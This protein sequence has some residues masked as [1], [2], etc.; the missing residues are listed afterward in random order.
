MS[1][2]IFPNQHKPISKHCLKR[3]LQTL[4]SVPDWESVKPVE[5][6]DGE[7]EESSAH[8]PKK[9]KRRTKKRKKV[10]GTGAEDEQNVEEREA[11][12]LKTPVKKR[13][14]KPKQKQQDKEGNEEAKKSE[15]GSSAA[16][17]PSV[18][19]LTRQQWKNKIKS[20]RRCKN[21]FLN[22]ADK[23]TEESVKQKSGPVLGLSELQKVQN[24]QPHERIAS[25]EVGDIVKPFNKHK[26]KKFKAVTNGSNQTKQTE[27]KTNPH[28]QCEKQKPVKTGPNPNLQLKANK[29]RRILNTHATS[30]KNNSTQEDEVQD[31]IQ[32]NT[33]EEEVE[34]EKGVTD[35]SSALRSRMEKR[36]ESARFRYINEL[37]YT[38]TSGE[39]KRMFKQDPDAIGIYHKGYTAQVKY[40]P[41]NP[42]DSI[43]AFIQKK[44]SSLVVA[45]FGCGDCKIARSVKNKVHCFDLAPVCDLV[46]VCDMANVLLPD[47]SVDIAVF[48]LSLMGTNLTDFLAEANRV[49]V[50]G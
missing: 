41:A 27:P 19:T 22:D 28:N 43:I 50:M 11:E 16:E 46:T 30:T 39:A 6:S 21:K 47:S 33:D 8:S 34:E 20:K 4:G 49:L 3:T 5:G 25:R 32:P 45:D 2:F 10:S 14:V 17:D 31:L 23:V 29:L 40:W 35:R 38:S 9:K 26:S 18:K 37:L 36:L 48:C 24:D 7:H 12:V 13:R 42:V 1:A 15:E 44:P